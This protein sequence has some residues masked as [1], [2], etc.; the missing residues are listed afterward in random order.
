MNGHRFCSR[1]DPVSISG[2]SVIRRLNLH[3]AKS[4]CVAGSV[5]ICIQIRKVVP[6]FLIYRT[7]PINQARNKYYA[8]IAK[9]IRIVSNI[10]CLE[11]R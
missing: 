7:F 9:A 10:T 5:T 1:P 8:C 3:N 6:R 2:V 4:A 11:R